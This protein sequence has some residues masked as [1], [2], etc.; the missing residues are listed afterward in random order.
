MR[1]FGHSIHCTS[2]TKLKY[3]S[4]KKPKRLANIPV[5]AANTSP[6][7]K[8]EAHF[9]LMPLKRAD[10]VS[11]PL[12]SETVADVAAM[13]KDLDVE[14]PFKGNRE[15]SFPRK[16]YTPYV[17]YVDCRVKDDPSSHP[18]P[19]SSLNNGDNE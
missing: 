18:G 4:F 11:Y 14:D 1:I 10:R 3:R 8:V 19:P 5:P 12:A 6:F 7:P 17:T 15:T 2:L 16:D 9:R 13:I